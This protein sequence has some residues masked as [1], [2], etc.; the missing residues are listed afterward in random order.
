MRVVTNK[1]YGHESNDSPPRCFAETNNTQFQLTQDASTFEQTSVR[2]IMQTVT[3]FQILLPNMEQVTF[4]KPLKGRLCVTLRLSPVCKTR[5]LNNQWSIL[6]V[7]GEIY[8]QLRQSITSYETQTDLPNGCLLKQAHSQAKIISKVIHQPNPD[9]PTQT[10]MS[11]NT[12]GAIHCSDGRD[13]ST[14]QCFGGAAN[15]H[16]C[17][18]LARHFVAVDRALG[19]QE[20]HRPPSSSTGDNENIHI[21]P[22]A[23]TASCDIIQSRQSDQNNQTQTF[24]KPEDKN[25]DRTGQTYLTNHLLCRV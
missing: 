13:F 15:F 9:S 4:I 18:R 25:T 3:S 23:R 20:L 11:A 14:G 21:N 10:T 16:C 19:F 8:T 24:V 5:T 7:R 22:T 12:D 6:A 17:R 1:Y 2:R